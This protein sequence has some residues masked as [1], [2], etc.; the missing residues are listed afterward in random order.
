MQKSQ[1]VGIFQRTIEPLSDDRD[2]RLK[3]LIWLTSS[4]H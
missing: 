2:K 1:F 4:P 3:G